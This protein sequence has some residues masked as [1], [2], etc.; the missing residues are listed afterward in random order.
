MSEEDY[1]RFVTEIQ[2][3]RAK[4]DALAGV[5]AEE[6]A[7]QDQYVLLVEKERATKDVLIETLQ[8]QIAK[9]KK[10]RL[11][12]GVIIGGAATTGG[13]SEGAIGIG[14]KIDLW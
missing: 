13:R 5:L 4:S 8:I 3:L 14:W 10:S 1:R 2:I 9:L 7:S 12:P 6:R 11:Y